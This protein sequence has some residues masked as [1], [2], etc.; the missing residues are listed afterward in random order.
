MM[1][2]KALVT[3]LFFCK[4]CLFLG[5]ISPNLPCVRCSLLGASCQFKANLRKIPEI[6]LPAL[7]SRY[8]DHP[9]RRL[10]L[11]KVSQKLLNDAITR[12]QQCTTSAL[13]QQP[14]AFNKNKAKGRNEDIVAALY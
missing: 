5:D 8:P 13:C 11:L 7:I 10:P 3:A 4:L 9:S 12:S 2:K 14:T 1:Q 6:C